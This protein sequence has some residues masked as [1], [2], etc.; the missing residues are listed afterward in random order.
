MELQ[1]LK[2][3]LIRNALGENKNEEEIAKF[4]GE[5]IEVIKKIK[6]LYYPENLH[7]NNQSNEES[8]EKR[9]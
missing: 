6:E 1:Q 3:D 4:F 2:I 8:A 9:R 7:Q 5:N